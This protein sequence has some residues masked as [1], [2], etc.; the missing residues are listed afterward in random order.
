MTK[1]EIWKLALGE[2][3][4]VDTVDSEADTTAEAA[5]CRAAWPTAC[6][7]VLAAY[8]WGCCRREAQLARR[9]DKASVIWSHVHQLPE[10]FISL[11][12]TIPT[13]IDYALGDQLFF[14]D[15]AHPAIVYSARVAPEKFSPHV[16]EL[17]AL[18][19]ALHLAT[20][21]RAGGAA[22]I[23]TLHQRYML[24]LADARTIE[25]R[26]AFTRP[27]RPRWRLCG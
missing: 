9:A 26:G 7:M 25:V 24:A 6:D 27:R 18:K 2:I 15:E 21:L 1:I 13:R 4:C 14:S 11:R 19:L 20:S 17:V 22:L 3:G 16:A 5:Q 10:D 8:P 12:S 23:Q